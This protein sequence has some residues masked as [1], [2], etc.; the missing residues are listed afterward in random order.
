MLV[1]GTVSNVLARPRD[2]SGDVSARRYVCIEMEIWQIQ[3]RPEH[4]LVT[5]VAMPKARRS[6]AQ[7]FQVS[8]LRIVKVAWT[9][10]GATINVTTFAWALL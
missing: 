7:R 9:R 1:H 4:P 6:H 5:R 3:M 10:D 8:V 2:A